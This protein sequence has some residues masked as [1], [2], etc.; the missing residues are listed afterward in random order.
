MYTHSLASAEDFA[1]I[2]DVDLTGTIVICR[3]G[4]I[5]RGNK[6][7]F[8]AARGAAGVLIY[9]GMWMRCFA[10]RMTPVI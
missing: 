10:L 6:A 9:T 1:A 3:Y 2:A 4:E 8:A 7:D 5:Y